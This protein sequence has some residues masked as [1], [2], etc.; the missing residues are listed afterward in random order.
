M[1]TPHSDRGPVN[2]TTAQ[3]EEVKQGE[4]DKSEENRDRKNE[5]LIEF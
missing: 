3:V 2:P 4:K 1:I 5:S